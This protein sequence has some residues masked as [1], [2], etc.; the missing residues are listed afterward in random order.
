MPVA[1]LL[2]VVPGVAESTVDRSDRDLPNF[3]AP[4]T[5]DRLVDV[6]QRHR[7]ELGSSF[8]VLRVGDEGHLQVGDTVAQYARKAG[9]PATFSPGAEGYVADRHTMDPCTNERAVVLGVG[10][11]EPRAMPG[12]VVDHVGLYPGFDLDAFLRLSDSAKGRRSCSVRRSRPDSPGKRRSSGARTRSR[13]RRSSADG[14][15]HSCG[16]AT[17]WRCW[18]R[19]RRRHRRWT[20]TTCVR[21]CGASP[22]TSRSLDPTMVSVSILDRDEIRERWPEYAVDC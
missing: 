1:G 2:V 3:V 16:T 4:A 18:P 14:P 6:V 12:R 11:D 13:S 21:C 9:L 20:R 19:R 17:T 7:D 10:V 8:V 5:I 22:T 15:V